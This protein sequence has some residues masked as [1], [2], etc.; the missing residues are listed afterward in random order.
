MSNDQNKDIHLKL[1]FRKILFSQGYW[2]PVEVELSQ[3]ED[4]G[5]S[6]KRKSL[7]DLDVLGF[8]FDRFFLAHTIV[9]DCKTGKN[10][11]DVQRLFW[12]KGVKDYFGADQAYLIHS[13]IGNHARGIAPKL[14]LRVLDD[15][16]LSELEKILDIHNYPLPLDDI[17]MHE[18]IENLWGVKVK[19]GEKPNKDQLLLKK[20][21]TFLSYF[22]WYVEPH[23]NIFRIINSF[24]EVAHLLDE[25]I[26]EHVLLAYVGLERFTHSLLRASMEIMSQG[27]I[28]IQRDFRHYLYGGP[29]SLREKEEFFKLLRS[30]TDSDQQLDPHYYNDVVELLGRMIINPHGA[31]D[32]LRHIAAIYIWC[33]YMQNQTL[34]PLGENDTENLPAIVLSRDIANTFTNITGIKRALYSKIEAL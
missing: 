28:N 19:K 23:R 7:T 34:I 13:T 6:L 24:S 18:N 4:S 11:S 29:L 20:V 17:S 27:G 14:G 33:N 16:A 21:Y 31:S 26:P 32:V 22:Y 8:R 10:V 15:K 12:L 1:K 25:S 2:S 9:G 3:F 30:L 5:T